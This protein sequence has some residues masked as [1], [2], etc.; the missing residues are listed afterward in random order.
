MLSPHLSKISGI[1]KEEG[2]Y[3]VSIAVI[4]FGAGN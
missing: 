3:A 2:R 1:I 4:Y